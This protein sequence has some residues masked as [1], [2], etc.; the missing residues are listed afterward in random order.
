MTIKKSKL[1]EMIIKNINNVCSK[2]NHINTPQT[3]ALVEVFV[4]F[5]D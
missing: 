3:K 4:I 5:K 1:R 2:L